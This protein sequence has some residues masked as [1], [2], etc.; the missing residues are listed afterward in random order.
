MNSS[1]AAADL[2]PCARH[3]RAIAVGGDPCCR[4]CA[5]RPRARPKKLGC[6]FGPRRSISVQGDLGRESRRRPRGSAHARWQASG[7]VGDLA[8]Q[9]NWQAPREDRMAPPTRP[10]GD[11]RKKPGHA[12]DAGRGRGRGGRILGSRSYQPAS[13]T[14][15]LAR[16][17]TEPER[18]VSI[19]QP[20]NSVVTRRRLRS[21]LTKVSPFLMAVSAMSISRN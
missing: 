10:A 16:I 5:A 20:P 18:G 6:I 4:T 3:S 9:G 21:P 19:A 7:D 8:R 13:N 15:P 11:G 2:A 1:R 17:F 12:H 14:R